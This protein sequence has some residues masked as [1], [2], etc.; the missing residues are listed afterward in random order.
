LNSNHI[1]VIKDFCNDNG[2]LDDKSVLF[3][4]TSKLA[5]DENIIRNSRNSKKSSKSS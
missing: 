5:K 2:A 3:M 4:L 1:E